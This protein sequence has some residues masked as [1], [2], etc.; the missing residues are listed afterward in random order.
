[1]DQ[2]AAEA[3]LLLHAAGELARRA[4]DEGRET[5]A[6]GQFGDAPVSL[7]GVLAEQPAEELE[8][9][10]HRQRRVEVLAQPLRHVGDTRADRAAVAGIAHV[11]V[12]HLHL[13]LLQLARTGDQR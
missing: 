7:F 11:A 13:A 4:F 10:E 6:T 9:L 5:R 1:V 8:V 2:R 3:E 12:E